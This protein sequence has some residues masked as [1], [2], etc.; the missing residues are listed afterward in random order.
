VARARVKGAII[1]GVGPMTTFIQLLFA[2]KS[3]SGVQGRA[4]DQEV[5]LRNFK[6]LDVQ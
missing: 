4:P 6:L 1:F 3:C 2:F 5:K